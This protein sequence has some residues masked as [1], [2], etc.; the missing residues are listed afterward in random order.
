MTEDHR[1]KVAG[2][3]MQYS[4][5]VEEAIEHAKILVAALEEA[6]CKQSRFA[7]ACDARSEMER[8][9]KLA[10]KALGKWAL[11]SVERRRKSGEPF[12]WDAPGPA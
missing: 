6:R 7:D 1:A 2:A 10:S 11:L 3:S 4:R 8:A 5:A 9:L 12:D